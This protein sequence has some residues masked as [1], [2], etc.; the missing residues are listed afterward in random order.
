[1][2][3]MPAWDLTVDVVIA[4]SGAAALSAALTTA[5]KKLE[6]IVFEKGDTLG[7]T[8]AMSGAG[9]WIPANHHARAAGISDSKA[10]ALAYL[11]AVAPDGWAETEDD[12]WAAFLDAAPTTLEFLE[13]K[14][15]LRFELI[16]EPDPMAEAEGGKAFGRMLSPKPLSR[17][18]AGPLAKHIRRS[19]LPHIFSYSEGLKHD[20]YG[21]PVKAAIAMG[22]TLLKRLFTDEAGQGSALIAGLLRGCLDAGVRIES[23]MPVVELVQDDSASVVGVVAG[24]GEKRIRVRARHGVILATGGFEWDTEMLSLH[25]PGLIDRLASPNTNTGDGQKLA[26]A[27]GAK[28]DRMDQANIYPCLPTRYEGRMHGLPITFQADAHAIIVN[29]KGRRFASELDFNLGESLDKRDFVTR[30][31]IN[32]PAYLVAD[33]RFVEQGRSFR[34]FAAKQKGWLIKASTLEELARKISVPEHA[35]KATVAR[36]NESAVAG[37]DK[38]F[39]RGESVWERYKSGVEGDAI[40]SYLGTIEKAPFYAMS[41]NRCIIGTK[42]GPRTDR[43]GRVL[44]DDKSVI[45]GLYCAGIAMANPIGTRAVGPGTTIGPCLTW[46]FICGRSIAASQLGD[47]N[48]ARLPT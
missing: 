28:L 2:F 34:H 11:R 25:F 37:R 30:Q 12:L 10:E 39:K 5:D 27:A 1:M 13:R 33:R 3:R 26:R 31:P 41:F 35:L 23:Q 43:E 16:G 22:P 48:A 17:R 19:T 4:G 46:G 24:I 14:T 6:T 44:R 15:P 36:W 42:G 20:F 21:A 47:L 45:A 18:V 38:D 9:T 7:G 40:A 8:S 32:M 29:G